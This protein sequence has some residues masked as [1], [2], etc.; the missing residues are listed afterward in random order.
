MQNFDKTNLAYDL[1]RFET[2][3]KP[4]VAQQPEIV[5]LPEAK[6]KTGSIFKCLL[7]AVVAFGLLFALISNKVQIS[8]LNDSIN[9]QNM[10]IM[11]AGKENS[12][13]QAV[14]DSQITLKT[15]EKKA[16]EELGLKKASQEQTEY[17]KT[18]TVKKIEITG[19]V[20]ET[21]FSSKVKNWFDDILEYLG[22]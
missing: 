22:F 16:T 5:A 3:E 12:R 4:Q 17:I 18:D 19:S 15:I 14:L 6:S 7:C 2:K 20:E 8:N 21:D 1:S 13:L 11:E 10:A 9:Q